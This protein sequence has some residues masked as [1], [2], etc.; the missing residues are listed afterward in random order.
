MANLKHKT[1]GIH[2]RKAILKYIINYIQK[3][4]YPPTVREIGDGV[5]LK[6]TSTVQ[7]H[8]TIM[9]DE[10]MIERDGKISSPRAIRVPGYRFVK[11]EE[12]EHKRA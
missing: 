1:K 11:E 8:L 12:N 3:H 10:G 2:V 4:G 6:S 5:G 9:L 7:N